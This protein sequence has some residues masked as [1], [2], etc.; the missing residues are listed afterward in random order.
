MLVSGKKYKTLKGEN[1]ELKRKLRQAYDEN[2]LHIDR[3]IDLENK[4]K[5]NDEEY[6]LLLADMCS[7]EDKVT[8]L[9]KDKKLLDEKIDN[10]KNKNI[11]MT[12]KVASNVYEIEELKE[13]VRK[14]ESENKDLKSKRSSTEIMKKQILN[15]CLYRDKK[16]RMVKT[17]DGEVLV[18]EKVSGVKIWDLVNLM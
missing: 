1:E 16:G 12:T 13:K 4:D 17:I 14:L 2:K 6:K 5:K 15:M 9:K 3:I 11:E 8:E 18:N 10:Y 7:L